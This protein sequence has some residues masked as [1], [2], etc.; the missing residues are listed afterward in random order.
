LKST[1]KADGPY[2][3]GAHKWV[4]GSFRVYCLLLE[5]IKTINIEFI[6]SLIKGGCICR[7]F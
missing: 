5:S 1:W 3:V 6:K 7:M 2:M 4:I